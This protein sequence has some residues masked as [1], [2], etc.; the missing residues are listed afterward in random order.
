MFVELIS[1]YC[2]YWSEKETGRDNQQRA[3]SVDYLKPKEAQLRAQFCD[4]IE[5]ILEHGRDASSDTP[6]VN[7]GSKEEDTGKEDFPEHSSFDSDEPEQ[8]TGGAHAGFIRRLRRCSTLC[9]E[10]I[11]TFED[12][13][14]WIQRAADHRQSAVVH[15][16]RTE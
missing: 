5:E 7:D 4:K 16:T 9:T 1:N 6:A 12:K 14:Y 15:K 13:N 11:G 3:F 2:Y 10:F 8:E